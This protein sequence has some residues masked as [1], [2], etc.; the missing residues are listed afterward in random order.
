MRAAVDYNQI[1]GRND[2]GKL[3]T[4]ACGVECAIREINHGCH[5]VADWSGPP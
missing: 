3:A 2:K 5:T 1:V 4:D